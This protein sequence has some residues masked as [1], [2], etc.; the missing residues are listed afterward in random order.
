M[1]QTAN[2]LINDSV[3]TILPS[4]YNDLIRRR[5]AG[6]EGERRL[7][8]AVLEDAMET[9]FAN[10]RGTTAKQCNEF[11][12]VYEW[13]RPLVRERGQLFSFQT[14]CDM[15]EIDAALLI[16]GMEAIRKRESRYNIAPQEC[17]DA[18][19]PRRLAA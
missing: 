13:F 12:E 19:M 8:W 11:E 1:I 6:F 2:N 17:R 7:L 14:I 18:G 3:S 5:T 9:Y 10:M 16:K 15:L 4:Q